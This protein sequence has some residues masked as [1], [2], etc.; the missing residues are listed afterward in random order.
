MVQTGRDVLSIKFHASADVFRQANGGSS[1][2][3][4]YNIRRGWPSNGALDE[5]FEP[6]P[7]QVVTDG[8]VVTLTGGKASPATFDAAAAPTDP[9][10][11]FVIGVD[12]LSGRR[13]GLLSACVIEL[14]AAH[15]ETGVY[16]A[17]D[18]LTAK[19]GKFAKAAA[20]EK[21]LARVLAFDPTSNRMRVLWHAAN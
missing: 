5:V 3:G 2:V 17:N 14:D 18:L 9:P 20:G 16:V 13:T 8:M 6:A 10:A 21:I 4:M 11:A 7:G 12:P 19:A 1:E 15:Y